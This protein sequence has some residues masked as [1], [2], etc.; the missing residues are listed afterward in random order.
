MNNH[1][2]NSKYRKWKCP[3]CGG[4]NFCFSRL[5]GSKA[6]FDP[7]C[8]RAYQVLTILRH[9]KQSCGCGWWKP[10]DRYEDCDALDNHHKHSY[11]LGCWMAKKDIVRIP[12]RK[13]YLR[14]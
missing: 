2:W 11:E 10:L 1:I 14:R 7:E 8:R 5:C 9:G 3:R 13:K 12:L 6:K 4:E